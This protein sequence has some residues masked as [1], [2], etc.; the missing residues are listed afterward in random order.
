MERKDLSENL[1]KYTVKHMASSK[2]EPKF[3]MKKKAKM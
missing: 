1:K 3:C 2:R